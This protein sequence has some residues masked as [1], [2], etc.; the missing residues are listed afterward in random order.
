MQIEH[1][2]MPLL[3]RAPSLMAALRRFFSAPSAS[4][5]VLVFAMLLM[6]PTLTVGLLGDDFLFR[7]LLRTSGMQAHP[8]ALFGLF[9][10][11]DGL[12]EH[13]RHMRDI[14]L[15]PW[16]AAENAKMNFWRPLSELTHWLDFALW[17]SWPV[18]MHVHSVAWYGLLVF[19]LGRLYKQIDPNPMRAHVSMLV[20]A[21]STMHM[22]AV[23]WLA[24]RNQLISA[25]FI[26]LCLSLHHRWR[27]GGSTPLRWGAVLCFGLGLASA[28]AGL[29]ALAYVVAYA[30]FMDGGRSLKD[31]VGSVLPYLVLMV[32]WRHQYNAWGYGSAELGGYIDPGSDPGRF[33]HALAL[34]LPTLLIAA[35]TGVTSTVLPALPPVLK[36]FYAT[37]AVAALAGMWLVSLRLGIWQSKALRF[38]AFGALLALVPVCAA[39][40]NDRLLLNAELGLSA[41]LGTVF[42]KALAGS[43]SGWS[44]GR[45]GT[46]VLVWG[47][48]L[49]HLV[50]FPVASVAMSV[51]MSRITA[52][53]SYDEPMSLPDV[54]AASGKRM[55]LINPPKA[56]FVGYYQTV[57]RFHGVESGLSLQ[58]LV[59]GEQQLTLQV[60]DPYRIVL[61]AS[62]GFGDEVT[63]DLSKLPMRVGD[64]VDT[65]AFQAS[66]LSAK[67]DGR[68]DVVEMR[69]KARLDDPSLAFFVW[70]DRGYVAYTMPAPGS[71]EVPFAPVSV[72]KMMARRFGVG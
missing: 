25:C 45:K 6:L 59:S 61:K 18:L 67:P 55:V 36:P 19:L 1:S 5:W 57:R 4:R 53:A 35:L 2:A 64:K 42:V 20:F 69:F 31:R 9:T 48:M 51:A 32:V 15:F 29:A 23:V 28:E 50:V 41:V 12:P 65:A 11:S 58:A 16:W 52:V 30:C 66:V 34:R 7:E 60:I 44:G 62:K 49:V 54:P 3:A 22:L 38:L 39:E 71:A 26:V 24:A 56:V 21:V 46:R 40:P 17:P 27:Q 63:R 33:A 10:F 14:G 43:G 37:A 13:N 70:T 68:A 8:G 47:L 72:K